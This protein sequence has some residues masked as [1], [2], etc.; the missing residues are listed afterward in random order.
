MTNGS[1]LTPFPGE[2]AFAP[3]GEPEAHKAGR[4]IWARP[5][6]RSLVRHPGRRGLSH[7]H[8]SRNLTMLKE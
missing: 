8:E 1:L 2:P 7:L 3:K 5:M 4:L 6:P